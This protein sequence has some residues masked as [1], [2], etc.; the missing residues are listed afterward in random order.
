MGCYFIHHGRRNDM[1]L[2]IILKDPGSGGGQ[3]PTLFQSEDGD[4][5]VQGYMVDS[6]VG[7]AAQIPAGESVVKVSKTFIEALASQIK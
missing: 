2:N 7:K 4:Y 1:K 3:S 6:E 5:Y